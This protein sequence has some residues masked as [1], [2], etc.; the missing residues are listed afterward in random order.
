MPQDTVRRRQVT[1]TP[2]APYRPSDT[3][4]STHTLSKILDMRETRPPNAVPT[5]ASRPLEPGRNG[6]RLRADRAPRAN[7]ADRESYAY[8]RL[9]TE[10]VIVNSAGPS[11]WLQRAIDRTE[12]GLELVALLHSFAMAQPDV[13]EIEAELL[14]RPK[15]LQAANRWLLRLNTSDVDRA[16]M[17]MCELALAK[18]MEERDGTPHKKPT[19]GQIAV[20]GMRLAQDSRRQASCVD[21]SHR[22]LT[23]D[24]LL[25]LLPF[26]NGFGGML[27]LD[28]SHNEITDSSLAALGM[29]LNPHPRLLS[30]DLRGNNITDAGVQ[31]FNAYVL[32]QNRGLKLGTDLQAVNPRDPL[33][34]IVTADIRRSQEA[35]V[36]ETE[37]AL[38]L[39]VACSRAKTGA[40]AT[41]TL[42]EAPGMLRRLRHLNLSGKT[43]QDAD[44]KAF[45]DTLACEGMRLVQL[46]FS[47][48]KLPQHGV[49]TLAQALSHAHALETLRLTGVAIDQAGDVALCK[50]VEQTPTLTH[51]SLAGA[52]LTDAALLARAGGGATIKPN[53][54][55]LP[56]PQGA[57]RPAPKNAEGDSFGSNDE[58]TFQT[59][60]KHCSLLSH[61]I[62]SL[63]EHLRGAL[64]K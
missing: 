61:Q 38:P 33:Q 56:P 46:D 1:P 7:Q 9:A 48:S 27:C 32:S 8:E 15:S 13:D 60:A 57:Q 54:V 2:A 18:A 24:H 62:I 22:N 55:T 64:T 11:Q 42:A 3:Q 31:S 21:M 23:D 45:A 16:M 51:I 63:Y 36:F 5:T 40:D 28:L 20:A 58:D 47:D 29:V 10:R 43:W 34:A 6:V 59:S 49:Q 19:W 41:R 17:H 35:A 39:R 4:A 14:R 52:P 25:Q 26:L 53:I 37:F 50:L 30:L 12:G 44:L